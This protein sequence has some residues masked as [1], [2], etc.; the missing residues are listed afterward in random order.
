M[1]TMVWV[2]LFRIYVDEIHRGIY[3][4]YVMFLGANYYRV[5]GS[6]AIE[7]ANLEDPKDRVMYCPNHRSC[8]FLSRLKDL[9]PVGARCAAP[10]LI[11]T[12]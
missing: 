11:L 7:R 5:R 6:F 1:Q 9:K 2:G 3:A 10:K 12:L 8:E 4:F